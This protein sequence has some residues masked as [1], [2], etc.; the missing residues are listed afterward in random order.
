MLPGFALEAGSFLYH[1]YVAHFLKVNDPK[2]DKNQLYVIMH[3]LTSIHCYIFFPMMD[4]IGFVR[5]R[6]LPFAV[7]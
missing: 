4:A 5:E 7:W 3:I 6:N 2:A 1:G